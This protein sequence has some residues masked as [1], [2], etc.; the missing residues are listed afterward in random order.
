MPA[1][2]LDRREVVAGGAALGGLWSVSA[3]AA[4]SND[5]VSRTRQ[6]PVRG[7]R[8]DGI[9][10]FKGVPY[11]APTGGADRFAPPRPP[12]A[13][14]GVLDCMAFGDAAPQLPPPGSSSRPQASETCLTLNVWTPDPSPGRARPVMVWVHGGGFSMGS[15]ASP[16]TDGARLAHRGDVVVVTLNHRLNA[17]GY[18]YLGE[19]GSR[20][21][22]WANAG[23]QDIVAALRWVRDNIRAFG[24][25]PNNVTLFG[26]SGGGSKVA[27][28]LAMPSAAGL[29]HRAVLQSGFGV[30]AASPAEA[31]AMARRIMEA[32]GVRPG[33]VSALQAMPAEKLLDALAKVAKGDPTIGPAPVADGLVL[34]RAAF[35][36]AAPPATARIPIIVGHTRTEV[37]GL[38][39]PP[40]AFSLDWSSLKRLLTAEIPTADVDGLVAGMRKLSPDVSPSDLYFRIDTER[41]MGRNANIVAERKAMQGGAPV[42]A[43][44]LDWRTPVQGGRLRTPHALDIPLV[45]DNLAKAQD[46]VG[47]PTKEAQAV[48]DAMSEAWIAFARTGDPGRPALP[49]PAFD[50]NRRSTMVFDTVSHVAS[51]PV[52]QE[53][54]LLAAARA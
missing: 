7:L 45:F 19:F 39:A 53:R 29:V 23:Q 54:R 28:V 14:S 11:G 26:Q 51:D 21:A 38:F 33:D 42:F 52:G 12:R 13:W 15:G 22:S 1:R 10:V 25:D 4:E 48:A 24:G 44:L 36:P 27:A 35:T 41:G 40:E 8:E 34:P 37:T 3:R 6:G 20:Y 9:A 50:L 49:W 5:P 16:N 32:A 2:M 46:Q 47:P 18:L 30:T 31:S 17:F 43:Y